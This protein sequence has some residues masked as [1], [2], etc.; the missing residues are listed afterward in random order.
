MPPQLAAFARS[1]LVHVAFAFL[2][3]G[4][5]AVFAN[6]A[7]GLA[8]ALTAGLVQGLASGAITLALKRFLEAAS[9]RLSGVW[10]LVAPPAISCSA[11]LVLLVT[12]HRLAGTAHVWAT[13]S[14]PWAVSSTYA[15]VYVWT[16]TRERAPARA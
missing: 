15:W 11:I 10:A 12:A 2:A 9:M 16:L 3:M 14:L 4:A 1:T 13:I 8:H 7:A 6:R 5:W